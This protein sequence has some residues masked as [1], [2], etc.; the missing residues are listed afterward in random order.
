M[1][2]LSSQ[3][4]KVVM[5]SWYDVT[6]PALYLWSSAPKTHNLNYENIGQIPSGASYQILD[7]YS[8]K[9]LQVWETVIAK[10]NLK[11]IL[12]GILKRKKTLGKNKSNLNKVWTSVNSIFNVKWKSPTLWDPTDSA[13][14]QAPLSMEFCR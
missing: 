12:D 2:P 8:S 5:Y 10:R 9:L 11:S 13:A 4:I 7:Q 14:H 1:Q 3:V 6:R